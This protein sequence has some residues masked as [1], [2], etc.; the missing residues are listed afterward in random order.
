[1]PIFARR[2]LRA[3]VDDISQ[4]TTQAKVNDLLS[5]LESR[6]TRDAMAAEAE[7]SM[8]WAI[9]QVADVTVEPVAG[10]GRQPDAF[11]RDLFGSGGAIVEVRALS[12][13]SFSG[14]KPM[15]RTAN[16]LASTADRI[17]KRAG[18]HLAFEFLD[19]SYWDRRY[20]RERC[21]DP[22][23]EVSTGVEKLLRDWII[24]RQCSDG[25]HKLHV[26]DGKTDLIITWSDVP[27]RERPVFCRMPPV[28][29]DLEDN[30]VYKALKKK[31]KQIG[32][33][34]SEHLRVVFLFDAGCELL[35][36][37][38]RAASYVLERHGEDI[39]RHALRKLSGIDIVCVCSPFRDWRVVLGPPREVVW[40]VTCF[41][42][43]VAVPESEYKRLELLATKLPR[44]RF[45]GYQAR[46]IHR[47]G[48][49]FPNAHG[50]YKGTEMT[51]QGGAIRVRISSRLLQE[52]LAGRLDAERFRS[53][54]FA[55]D[56]N[57]FKTWLEKGQTIQG[58]TF[59][60]GG[61]D[62]DDD[63]VVLDFGAD[64]GAR[65]LRK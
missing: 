43:R 20:H 38:G 15:V 28:A 48:G 13:D 58:A 49:F 42:R 35:R 6:N 56:D 44:A 4:L 53:A 27:A 34:G 3:M 9:S 57:L 36:Y 55:N 47:R 26:T 41:D 65:S 18:S 50:R 52:Y 23:F 1:M 39:V 62:E 31:S 63:Y 37:I 12:D 22:A 2:R 60:S 8:V 5:R 30:P 11:S 61:V 40:N 7:L 25:P 54:A 46:Q 29:Y 19:R 10:N 21:V 17:A 14:R 45:E 64:W 16:I 32:D 51:M 59:E 33:A 24:R